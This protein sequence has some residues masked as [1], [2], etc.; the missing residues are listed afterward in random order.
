MLVRVIVILPVGIT[1]H[2][3]KGVILKMAAEKSFE[4]RLKRWLESEGIYA[5]GTPVQ[6]MPF[7]PCG[8][9]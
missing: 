5:L 1:G 3:L 6:D 8:Y 2:I 9:Y 4:E 7:P